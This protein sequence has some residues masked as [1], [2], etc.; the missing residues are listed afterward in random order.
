[1]RTVVGTNGV[2]ATSSGSRPTLSNN[3]SNY[4]VDLIAAQT[5]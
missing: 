3:N 5:L 2:Y 1:M 4:F